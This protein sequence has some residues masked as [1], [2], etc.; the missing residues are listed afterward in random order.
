[1]ISGIRKEE[2]I[3][4]ARCNL[5]NRTTSGTF[6]SFICTGDNMF[7]SSFLHIVCAFVC[8]WVWVLACLPGFAPVDRVMDLFT[9]ACGL[10]V[11]YEIHLK[12]FV[13]NEALWYQHMGR[14]EGVIKKE[15]LNTRCSFLWST[16]TFF[17]SPAIFIQ[18]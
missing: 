3:F 6:Y 8:A 13:L 1:M 18:T 2:I 5:L 9:V 17:F 11:M 15:R 4:M 16:W 14:P 12:F 7:S 10:C